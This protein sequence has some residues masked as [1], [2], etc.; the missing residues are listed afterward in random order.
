MT[1][2]FVWACPNVSNYNMQFQHWSVC[3]A[4][5]GGK[6][7]RLWKQAAQVTLDRNP[8]R[9]YGNKRTPKKE[10]Q[11]YDVIYVYIGISWSHL[12]GT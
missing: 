3:K 4:E 5:I 1:C 8:E 10:I 2:F 7:H 12:L 9:L 6:W 11:E